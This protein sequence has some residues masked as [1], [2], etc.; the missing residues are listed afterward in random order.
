MKSKTLN[1]V[2]N[3]VNNATPEAIAELG[4][5][6]EHVNYSSAFAIG[7][8]AQ[9]TLDTLGDLPFGR[10]EGVDFTPD[11]INYTVAIAVN[12]GTKENPE[13]CFH[14]L[15]PMIG[16]SEK[17]LK[18]HENSLVSNPMKESMPELPHAA[19]QIGDTVT[20]D[21]QDVIGEY[22]PAA[23][24]VLIWGVAY[25]AGKI[26]YDINITVDEYRDTKGY[27]E[28]NERWLRH[29]IDRVDGVFIEPVGGWDAFY[30]KEKSNN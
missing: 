16:V 26:M 20:F 19:H 6:K 2:N 4:L 25:V 8:H 3:A 11:G 23:I 29:S 24:P 21:L 15:R 18:A 14:S 22:N 5:R 13:Y 27:N 1:A 17:I 7:E 12:F 28:I 10:I 30:G 9:L